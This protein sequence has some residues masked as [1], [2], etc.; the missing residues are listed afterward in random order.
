MAISTLFLD[1]TKTKNLDTMT[2]AFS[3]QEG[4]SKSMLMKFA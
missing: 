4:N 3:G 2:I 1:G